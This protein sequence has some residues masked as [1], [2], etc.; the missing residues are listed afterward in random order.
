MEDRFNTAA[1]WTLFAGVVALGLTSV[2]H[3]YFEADKNP[4]PEKMGYAIAGVVSSDEGAAKVLPI[5]DRLAVADVA[6]GEQTFK[7]C[8]SC[9][10]INQGGPNG[11][12][13]NLYHVVGEVVAQ[14][15]GGYPFSDALKAVG[16]N[17]DFDKLDH[18]L[19]SPKAFANGTKMTF[20]GLEDP[21]DRANVIAYLNSQ[22]SNLPL[23]KPTAAAVET[24]GAAGAKDAAGAPAAAA[25][26]ATGGEATAAGGAITTAAVPV[27]GSAPKVG[28]NKAVGTVG[29]TNSHQ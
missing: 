10:V 24:K 25:S 6:K 13:P 17:W 7:K 19:T 18:W 23:P 1:G 4:R 5:A 3:H 28:D 29:G 2:S 22:G 12:G 16:G 26:G 15:V 8:T 11:I 9:H 14:G 21:Q 27:A 20:A